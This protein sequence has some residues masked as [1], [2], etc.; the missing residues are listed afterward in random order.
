MHSGVQLIQYG[1]PQEC[2]HDWHGR[3][4]EDVCAAIEH[5]WLEVSLFAST[6][7]ISA[8][9]LVSSYFSL[10]PFFSC[11]DDRE[12]IWLEYGSCLRCGRLGSQLLGMLL[13]MM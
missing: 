12:C 8:I 4:G 1:E 2:W 6:W 7:V 11:Y 9:I 10:S 3:Y 13:S 5:R